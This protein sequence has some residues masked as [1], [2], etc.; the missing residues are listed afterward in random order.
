MAGDRA[1]QCW[2][3][4]RNDLNGLRPRRESGR[5]LAPDLFLI[6]REDGSHGPASMPRLF[7]VG[8]WT[9]TGIT[10]HPDKV[11]DGYL[12]PFYIATDAHQPLEIWELDERGFYDRPTGSHMEDYFYGLHFSSCDWTQGCLR[13][14][15][16]EDLRWLA[17]AV[18]TGDQFIVTDSSAA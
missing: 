8:E 3:K 9:I 1:V 10:P 17:R 15:W 13:I 12:Y 11:R 5:V 14:A 4:T 6:T 2:C 7:P 18:K 16:E